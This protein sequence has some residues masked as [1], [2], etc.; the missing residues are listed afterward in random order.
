M[1]QPLVLASKSS[2]RRAVLEGAGIPLEITPADVDERG[3]EARA[4][5]NDP[6]RVARLLA[7]EKAR[8]IAATLPGR[9]VLGA[10]QTLALGSQRFSKPDGA[11]GAKAQLRALSGQTHALHSGIALVR[12]GEVLLSHVE[13]AR[14]TMRPLGE[15]FITRYVAA[16]GDR[17][18]QSVG[19]YQLEGLGIHLF[20]RIDGDHFTILGMPL[21][22]L[23]EY[24][25]RASYVAH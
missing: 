23:L 5:E 6:G 25:R 8:A 7:E 12:D 21:V 17:V 10:D 4:G 1:D 2:A 24:L 20:A 16:A 11:D 15:D 13:V 19:G 18:T 3:I 22:P 14:L 9:L